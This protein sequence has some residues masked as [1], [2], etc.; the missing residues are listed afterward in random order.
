MI[1]AD[2]VIARY[3]RAGVEYYRAFDSLTDA[4]DFLHAGVADENFD[5]DDIESEV[6]TVIV[7]A[8]A[9]EELERLDQGQRD[10]WLAVLSQ[11]L[12]AEKAPSPAVVESQ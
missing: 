12:A 6:G 5:I 10:G 4:Y 2:P 11:R 7:S 8:Q 3:R 9:F 1:I